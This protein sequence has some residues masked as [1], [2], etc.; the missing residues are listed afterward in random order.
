MLKLV[1]SHLTF[2]YLDE[3]MVC[4]SIVMPYECTTERKTDI[5]GLSPKVLCTPCTS[6]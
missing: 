3:Q 6:S 4:L 1:P 5:L 2:S